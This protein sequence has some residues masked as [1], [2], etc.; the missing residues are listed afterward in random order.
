MH[1]PFC[2]LRR[3]ALAL[4]LRQRSLRRLM[5]EKNRMFVRVTDEL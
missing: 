2:A 5:R 3:D 1:P 4:A